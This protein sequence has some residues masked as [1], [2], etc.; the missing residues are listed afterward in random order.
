MIGLNDLV[1]L[2]SEAAIIT[3]CSVLVYVSMRAYRRNKSKSM[4]AMSIGF[5]VILVGSLIEELIVEMLG[6][7]LILAHA[8]EN[9]VVAVGLLILVYSIYGVR[10]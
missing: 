7:Q 10:E 1:L 9:S 4:L 6:Y 5:M 8:L 2:S 3:L